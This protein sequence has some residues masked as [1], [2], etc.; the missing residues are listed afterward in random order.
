[1]KYTTPFYN[2]S[3]PTI[4]YGLMSG[5][6]Y[7]FI[8]YL[9]DITL[10]YTAGTGNSIGPSLIGGINDVPFR[11]H[12]LNNTTLKIIGQYGS[13]YGIISFKKQ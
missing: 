10:G 1:V 11:I 3:T 9:S 12:T 4:Q 13:G 6:G 2:F 8:P 5:Y 7:S